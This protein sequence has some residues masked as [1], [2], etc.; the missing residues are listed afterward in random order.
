MFGGG[1]GETAGTVCRMNVHVPVEE[2]AELFVEL[3]RGPVEVT[4]L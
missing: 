2:V 4:E 3:G 1:G